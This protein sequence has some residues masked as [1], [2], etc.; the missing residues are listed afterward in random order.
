MDIYI[1]KIDNQKGASTVLVIFMMMVLI[2]LGALAI[3]SANVN[4]K[5]SKR[6]IEWNTMYYELDEKGE[7]FIYELDKKLAEA[8]AM[9]CDYLRNN[10]YKYTKYMEIPQ[11]VQNGIYDLYAESKLIDNNIFNKVYF[12]YSNLYV[13]ELLLDF[14]DLQVY[15]SN[16]GVFIDYVLMEI[17]FQ[18]QLT[19][20]DQCGLN[21][22]IALE[23]LEY[24]INQAS[25]VLSLVRVDDSLRYKIEDWYEYQESKSLEE[26]PNELWD[27]NV[28]N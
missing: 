12:Y 15:S 11:E 24:E 26:L 27:G 13:N 10:G 20:Q 4:Y 19:G 3:T 17:R 7:M 23:P 22:C 21:V 25:D 2:T 1:K 28:N 6:V 5:L 16:S 9:A 18:S 14:A 8:E